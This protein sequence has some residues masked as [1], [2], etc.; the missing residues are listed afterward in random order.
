MRA[1]GAEGPRSAVRSVRAAVAVAVIALMPACGSSPVHPA[2]HVNGAIAF[3]QCMRSNGVLRFPD[4]ASSGAIPKESLS[5]LGV[6]VARF[7]AAQRACVHLLRNGGRPPDRS[8]RERIQALSL[9]FARCVRGHGLP[10]F[11]DPDGTGRFPDP[12]SVG[13]DQSAPKFQ[14]ANDACAAHRPP[15]IPSNANYDAWARTHTNG[16]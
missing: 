13:F 12:A 9:A 15:Y 3:A 11:P 1:A 10:N 8:E 4:P 2:V 7:Q 5:Q 6:D 16:S 14:A